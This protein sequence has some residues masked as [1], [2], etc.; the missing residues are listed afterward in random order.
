[1]GDWMDKSPYIPLLKKE[2][3]GDWDLTSS[4]LSSSIVNR[5]SVVAPSLRHPG[6]GHIGPLS[7]SL[8]VW[9]APP[10]FGTLGAR[11]WDLRNIPDVDF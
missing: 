4:E 10:A 5:C 11:R 1:M 3:E 8:L 9:G 7:A 2:T 6:R